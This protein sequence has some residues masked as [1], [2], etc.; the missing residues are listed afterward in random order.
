MTTP[1]IHT[2]AD[3]P[4]YIKAHLAASVLALVIGM[5]IL[6]R[7]KGDLI[8][9]SLGRSWVALMLFT[10]AISFSIQARGRFSLIHLLSVIVLVAVPL[11]VVHIRS[12]QVKRHMVTMVS[13]FAGLAIAGAFTLLPYR[14][15][16]QLVFAAR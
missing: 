10:A 16:G 1:E 9:K 13:A 3:A 7:K 5:V 15:L 4:W 2:L 6:L 8:H 14:M 12:G 11:G